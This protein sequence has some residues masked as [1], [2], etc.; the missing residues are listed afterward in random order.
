MTDP[1][2]FRVQ[3][4]GGTPGFVASSGYSIKQL[5]KSIGLEAYTVIFEGQNVKL[6]AIL[7]MGHQD[8]NDLGIRSFGHRKSILQ[9][10]QSYLQLY[11]QSCEMAAA[12][13]HEQAG[14]VRSAEGTAPGEIWR[15]I[16]N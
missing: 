7:G 13:A 8:L 15:H 11:L 6:D 14:H 3:Q 2:M 9:A 5:L 10:L 1:Q 12:R 4:V 16:G